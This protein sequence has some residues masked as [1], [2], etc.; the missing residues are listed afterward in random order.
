MNPELIIFY[1][2]SAC[3]IAFSLFVV[4]TRNL[5]RGAMAL[6]GAL[7]VMAGLFAFLG[8]DF[9]AAGQL[10]IY[11]GGVM[12]LLTFVVMFVQTPEI[13][14]LRQTSVRWLP[15]LALSIGVA[16]FLI[17]AFRRLPPPP[18]PPVPLVPTSAALGRLLL[19]DMGV[20]FEVISLVLLAALVGA[21]VFGLERES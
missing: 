12:L 9:L 20:P 19:G 6:T 10:L 2:L 18:A 17:Q 7:S 4:T 11:V 21:I 5:F 1:G 15:A 13:S 3:L 14:R 8:G 16:A